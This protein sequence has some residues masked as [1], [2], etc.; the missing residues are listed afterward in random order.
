MERLIPESLHLLLVPEHRMYI[1]CFFVGHRDQ[2]EDATA[3]R[4]VC[5]TQ[6][7]PWLSQMLLPRNT[8]RDSVAGPTDKAHEAVTAWVILVVLART[9]LPAPFCLT[10]RQSVLNLPRSHY[11]LI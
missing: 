8:T 6:T 4:C 2:R 9:A 7:F 1:R 3:S 5:E 10:H 11:P